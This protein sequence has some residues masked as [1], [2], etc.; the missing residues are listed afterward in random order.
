MQTR[1]S[2]DIYYRMV[3][4]TVMKEARSGKQNTQIHE[5][6]TTT[7]LVRL[8]V[9]LMYSNKYRTNEKLAIMVRRLS[10]GPCIKVKRLRILPN[11]S[12]S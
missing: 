12:L 10:I 1:K 2:G 6:N 11:Q 8:R 7:T 5:R 3:L 9:P 4:E